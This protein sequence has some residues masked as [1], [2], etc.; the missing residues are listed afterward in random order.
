[1]TIGGTNQSFIA[2]P[3]L[4]R[5]VGKSPRTPYETGLSFEPWFSGLIETCQRL[6]QARDAAARPYRTCRR[7]R[8][9]STLGTAPASSPAVLPPPCFRREGRRECRSPCR[10]HHAGRWSLRAPRCCPR[11]SDG[12]IFLPPVN[13]LAQRESRSLGTLRGFQFRTKA[14]REGMR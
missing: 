10:C 11:S 7:C 2:S 5:P 12:L 8:R 9:L 3:R 14:H 1:M 13:L 6:G 4:S